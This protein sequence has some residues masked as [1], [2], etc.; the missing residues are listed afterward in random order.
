MLKAADRLQRKLRKIG[1]F[2]EA[3][4]RGRF[5]R[6]FPSL[7]RFWVFS[8]CEI[9][10]RRQIVLFLRN[11]KTVIAEGFGAADGRFW[12][13]PRLRGTRRRLRDRQMSAEQHAELDGEHFKERAARSS[14][15]SERRH[16][17]L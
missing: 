3:Y 8:F 16:D 12:N 4:G 2:C 9:Y 14:R 5:T 10:Q 17:A 11:R 13:R 1:A 6:G 15:L 7:A